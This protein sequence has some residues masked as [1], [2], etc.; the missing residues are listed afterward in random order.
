[1]ATKQALSKIGAPRMTAS[2]RAMWKE[3]GQLRKAGAPQAK[4]VAWARKHRVKLR[5]RDQ[6]VFV[7]RHRANITV[8]QEKSCDERC[9]VTKYET[10]SKVLG[11]KQ[12]MSCELKGC[13]YD[14]N[15]KDWVCTYTCVAVTRAPE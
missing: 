3:Y 8:M 2:E 7:R 14:D 10:V 15:L 4:L 11:R 12:A 6:V 9:G 5:G 1:M 13:N